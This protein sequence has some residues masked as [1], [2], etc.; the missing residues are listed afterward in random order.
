MQLWA[1]NVVP[2]PWIGLWMHCTHQNPIH[3]SPSVHTGWLL[4]PET[5]LLPSSRRCHRLL[6]RRR[7]GLVRK[8]KEQVG[9]RDQKTLPR[10][11]SDHRGNPG[12]QEREFSSLER[13]EIARKE[14]RIEIGRKQTRIAEQGHLLC[15]VLC[16][17]SV[18]RQGCLWRGHCSRARTQHQIK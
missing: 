12:G 2:R 4:S 3:C 7:H 8:C 1:C 5:T 15:R 18:Q 11:T 17:D 6:L 9:E 14:M 13:T 16:S 10:H